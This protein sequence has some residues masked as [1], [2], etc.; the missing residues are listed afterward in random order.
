MRGATVIRVL[1]TMCLC[2]VT[3]AARDDLRAS[4]GV[5][6]LLDTVCDCCIALMRLQDVWISPEAD[7][8]AGILPLGICLS[9]LNLILISQD[10]PLAH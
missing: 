4:G 3:G 5:S 1:N 10:L 7:K 9:P 2:A 6:A 8:R